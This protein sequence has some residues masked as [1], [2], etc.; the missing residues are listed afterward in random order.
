MLVVLAAALLAHAWRYSRHHRVDG[1]SLGEDDALD[2]ALAL[3]DDVGTVLGECLPRLGNVLVSVARRSAKA[4]ETSPLNPRRHPWMFCFAVALL[5][6]TM[7]SSW[8]SLGEGVPH[9]PLLALQVWLLYAGIL[10]SGVVVGYVLLGRYLG[11]I[12][13]EQDEL[14]IPPR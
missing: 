9:D 10:A 3:L 13:H 1:T 14:L 2:D 8:H 5:S 11:L 12:R 4:L 7:F 6:G